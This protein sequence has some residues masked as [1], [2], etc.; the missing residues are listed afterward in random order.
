VE[1]FVD[2]ITISGNALR[3]VFQIDMRSTLSPAFTGIS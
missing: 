2:L 3:T 1:R